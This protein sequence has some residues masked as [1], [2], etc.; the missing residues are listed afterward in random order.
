MKILNYEIPQELFDEYIKWR[1]HADSY[2]NNTNKTII[3][4]TKYESSMR[5]KLCVE[6]IMETHKKICEVLNI[7]YTH[8][9]NNEFYKAFHKEVRKLTKLKG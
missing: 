8:D 5:W 6:K 1:I 2:M 9:E 4:M 3:P 7:E